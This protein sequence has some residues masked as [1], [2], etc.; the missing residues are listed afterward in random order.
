MF[1]AEESGEQKVV[2][3][4]YI[5]LGII[6]RI[7]ILTLFKWSKNIV[8]DECKDISNLSLVIIQ[9]TN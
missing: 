6:A 8:K 5:N 3:N 1:G 4:I 2:T 9:V 7:F